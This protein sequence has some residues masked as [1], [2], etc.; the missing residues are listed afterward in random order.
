[1]SHNNNEI[2]RLLLV[3]RLSHE[4]G[5]GC[6]RKTCRRARAF[7]G[8]AKACLKAALA[9][10]PHNVQWRARQDVLDAT[11][12]NIGAPERAAR[13]CMPADLCE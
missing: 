1:L 11:P 3:F 9:R 12:R 2:T 5:N 6:G 8:D 10:V 7:R 4:S 13:Q